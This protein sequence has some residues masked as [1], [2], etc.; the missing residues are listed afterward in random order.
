MRSLFAWIRHRLLPA[1][2]TAAGVTLVAAGLLTYTQPATAV[3]PIPTAVATVRP[4]PPRLALPTLGPTRAPSAEPSGATP[5]VTRVA[6]RVTVPQLR[7]DLPI[8]VQ[9]PSVTFP[10]CNVAMRY[11]PP[12]YARPGEPG[13]TYLY[14]HART[15]MFLPLLEQSRKN[16]GD[17]MLG[18]LV[19][20]YTSD[21]QV[22]L[23]EITQVLRG[24]SKAYRGPG[25]T[26]MLALQTSEGPRKGLPGYT[27][28]V[29]IVVATPLSSSPVDHATANPSPAPLVCQ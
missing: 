10:Y 7:I 3:S 27:G 15:G 21:D 16:K 12:L 22:F 17:G 2:L 5:P 14:A 6:T 19:Q 1:A 20:V 29:L 26:H 4:L 13:T 25:D 18:M 11:D 23:Y 24:Q 9:P 28:L 8:V